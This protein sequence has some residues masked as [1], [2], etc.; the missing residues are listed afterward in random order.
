VPYEVRRKLTARE[1]KLVVDKAPG[2]FKCR[3]C[4]ITW[5][6]FLQNNIP[7]SNSS[8]GDKRHNF[9]FSKPIYTES[10]EMKLSQKQEA[11]STS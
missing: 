4:E 10:V 6:I 2:N 3:F 11:E 7:C 1:K 8:L 5:S 9:D